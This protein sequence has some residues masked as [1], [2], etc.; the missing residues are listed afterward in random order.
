MPPVV[1][2]LVIPS[3][4][5]ADLIAETIRSALGQKLP[6]SEIIVVDDGSTDGTLDVL[7]GFQDAIRV[8]AGPNGGV[9]R[10]RNRGVDAAADGYITLCDS[11]DL[12]DPEFLSRIQP[13]M[14]ANAGVD[15]MY[16]NFLP[17]G[18]DET[19]QE[20]FATAPAGY[21]DG[22]VESDGEFLQ[23]IPDF[24]RRTLDFQ[25]LFPSGLTL[26][27]SFYF[28][29]GGY[30]PAFN[31]VGAE[32]W[33]FTLRVLSAGRVALCRKA[34]VRVRKH[35]GNDSA[36]SL[37]MNLGEAK[38]LEHALASHDA[39]PRYAAAIGAAIRHRK[40]AAFNLA[41]ERGDFTLA[42]RLL[43]ELGSLPATTKMRL[44][45]L[46]LSLPSFIR[47]RAWNLTQR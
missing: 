12:L 13:W 1:H 47:Q 46:I 30:D 16:T 6:F 36:D 3:Y 5:R 37:Y 40:L 24:Y 22:A 35:G 42:G 7:A 45:R 39:A 4:N 33:E 27:K 34:L 15:A 18:P 2:T 38:I 26:R 31:R 9:Q 23:D 41:F 19:G 28:R 21:F 25:P 8:I 14:T 10:A 17:F 44:K 29:I 43:A 11:D 20:K 32:D